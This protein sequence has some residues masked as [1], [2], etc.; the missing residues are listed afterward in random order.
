MK[1]II[2][3]LKDSLNEDNINQYVSNINKKIYNNLIIC[4]SVKYIDYFKKNNN[5]CTQ[6]YYDNIKCEYALLGHYEKKQS[7]DVIKNKIKKCIDEK[8][9]IILCIGNDNFD[10]FNS[11]KKQLDFYFNDINKENIIIAYEPYFMIGS[12]NKLNKDKI[13][14]NIDF[15]KKYFLNDIKV[16]YGGNVNESNIKEIIDICDGVLLG[17]TSYNYNKLLKIISILK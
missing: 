6:D 3:N 1:Y 11:L 12:N 4:P 16:L 17:R 10:D 15:I 5:I 7:Y 2:A 13:K 14:N 9:K 8:I